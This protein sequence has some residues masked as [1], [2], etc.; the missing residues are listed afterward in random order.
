ME[1]KQCLLGFFFNWRNVVRRYFVVQLSTDSFS[2]EI[3][4]LKNITLEEH[5]YFRTTSE[6]LQ[7]SE[8]FVELLV[9]SFWELK[10]VVL[11]FLTQVLIALHDRT[12]PLEHDIPNCNDVE[13]PC[14]RQQTTIIF[15]IHLYGNCG[16]WTDQLVHD[17]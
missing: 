14:K 7:C 17:Y 1:S 13:I 2:S 4:F 3:V 16:L 8:E 12:R 5:H 15:V 10:F 6:L 9:V 11:K